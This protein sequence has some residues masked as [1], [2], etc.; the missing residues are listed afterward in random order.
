M[1]WRTGWRGDCIQGVEGGVTVCSPLK[2]LE[3]V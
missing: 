2:A 1:E 3:S